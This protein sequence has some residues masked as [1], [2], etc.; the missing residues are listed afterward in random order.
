MGVL[1]V[2]ADAPFVD[3]ELRHNLSASVSRCSR[4]MRFVDKREGS[5]VVQGMQWLPV[6]LAEHK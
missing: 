2:G 3:R 6:S 5:V 1:S 4:E